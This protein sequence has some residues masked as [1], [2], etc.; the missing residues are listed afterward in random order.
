VGRIIPKKN[1]EIAIRAL[2]ALEK[3]DWTYT[4][5]GEGEQLDELKTL[6]RELG[7]ADRMYFA[8]Y[9]DDV[10]PFYAESDIFLLPSLWEGFGLVAAE[11]MGA[12]LAV[13]AAEVPGLAEVVGKDGVAGRLLPPM[14]PELW[15][16]AIEDALGNADQIRAMSKA[17]RERAA[18][19]SIEN[20]AKGYLDLYQKSLNQC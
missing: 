5:V 10:V 9:V 15:T 17:G 8:G 6:A 7:V 4:I 3:I 18:Q 2:A 20:T 14:V 12:G 19:Y 1:F 13:F 11:A 16:R